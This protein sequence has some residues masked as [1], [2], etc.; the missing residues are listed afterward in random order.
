MA[1]NILAK[2]AATIAAVAPTVANLVVPGSGPL[3]QT[4]MRAVTGAGPDAPIA[5]VAATLTAHPELMVE[6]QRLAMEHERQMAAVEVSRLAVVNATMQGEGKSE[7]WPQYSWRPFNGFMYGIA[8]V[9]IYF[10]LPLAGRPVPPVP[11][12]IW[13]GWGAILG[14]T[15]WARGKAKLAQAGDSGP[16]MIANVITAIKDKS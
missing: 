9:A 10:V 5:E 4:L 1:D 3:L 15:T 7:H 6:L 11:E 8:V 16:G 14:V 13:L 12:W 2:I